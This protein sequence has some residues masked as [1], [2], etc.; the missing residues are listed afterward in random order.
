MA[1]SA[2]FVTSLLVGALLIATA[3]ALGA[4]GTPPTQSPLPTPAGGASTPVPMADLLSQVRRDLSERLGL[5]ESAIETASVEAVEWPDGSLGCPEPG[6]SYTQAI[7]PG[8]KIVL[9]AQG[10]IYTYHTGP[11][12]FVLCQQAIPTSEPAYAPVLQS[13]LDLALADLGAQLGQTARTIRVLSIEE[14]TWTDSS[15]GCPQPGM[16]YLT[17][18]T[19]GYR[20]VLDADGT[21][22]PYHTSYSRVVLCQRD[23]G[24]VRPPPEAADLVKRARQD[25]AEQLDLPAD[26][27]RLARVQAVEWPDGSL[28]CPEPGKSYITMIIPGYLIAFEV[29]GQLYEYHT[30]QSDIVWC[31]NPP[32]G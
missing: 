8:T 30:S 25:L 31:K 18:L 32:E 24:E 27:V 2:R 10:Q 14:T 17:V 29:E 12:R 22:Y 5:A 20:I 23:A 15:L 26:Q 28:G 11:K 1:K 4:C 6:R 7:E 16:A 19:P 21:Q 3:G 9:R 13:V